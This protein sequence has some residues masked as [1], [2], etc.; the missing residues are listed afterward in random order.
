[1]AEAIRQ[2]GVSEVTYYRWRQEFGGLKIEQIKPGL[3]CHVEECC[4]RN[5]VAGFDHNTLRRSRMIASVSSRSVARSSA[6]N[7]L[8]FCSRWLAESAAA[9][10]GISAGLRSL[11]PSR[12]GCPNPLDP[13]RRNERK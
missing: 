1:M 9:S 2:I 5:I 8:N 4:R 3:Q 6:A 10:S 13:F 7:V 11:A 12:V